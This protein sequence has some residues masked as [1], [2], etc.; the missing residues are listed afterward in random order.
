M[1]GTIDVEM[2]HICYD[3]MHSFWKMLEN[4]CSKKQISFSAHPTLWQSTLLE[5]FALAIYVGLII[6]SNIDYLLIKFTQQIIQ[7]YFK[8]FLE[9]T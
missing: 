3:I 1:D 5:D 8:N 2:M 7:V 4:E 9:M 6:S